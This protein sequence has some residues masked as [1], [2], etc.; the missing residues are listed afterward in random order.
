MF[1]EG[2]PDFKPATQLA[3]DLPRVRPSPQPIVS[4]PFDFPETYSTA[5]KR[6]AAVVQAL[7]ARHPNE[8]ILLIGHGLSIQYLVGHTHGLRLALDTLLAVAAASNKDAHMPIIARH[9][10]G[11][12]SQAMSLVQQKRKGSL[13]IPY[14]CLTECIR[15]SPG[16][17]PWHYGVLMQQDFLSQRESSH[18]AHRQ[19]QLWGLD[20]ST[21]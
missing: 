3:A 20:N 11:E 5:R 15:Q 19:R 6:C 14:C 16:H 1:P 9:Q 2:P 17:G 8:S 18:E 10:A 21:A 12:Y 4:L 7:T 13:D